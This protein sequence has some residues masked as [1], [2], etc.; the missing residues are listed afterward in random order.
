[1]RILSV[2][3]FDRDELFSAVRRTPLRGFGGVQPYAAATIALQRAQ[4]PSRF[5]PA[6]RYVLASGVAKILKLRA[7]LLPHGLDMFALDGGAYI[8]ISEAPDEVVP[9]IPPIVE[10]SHEPDGSCVLVISD[11]MHRVF[12]ARS[13]G[14]P[15]SVV[16]VHNVPLE[17]PYYALALTRGWSEVSQLDELPDA[18]QKKEYR[19]PTNYK[20]LFR[21]FNAVFPGVQAQRKQS[22]PEHLRG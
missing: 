5:V 7:A 9:V 10:E 12:A 16:A 3:R 22:N 18:F 17:Y 21:D 13:I 6:Q 11:G 1:V 14:L 19:I 8:R 4:D 2:E 20:A 15:I